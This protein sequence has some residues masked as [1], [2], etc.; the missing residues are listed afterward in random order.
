MRKAWE[1]SGETGKLFP[2]GS[3]KI[4]DHTGLLGGCAGAAPGSPL[5][6]S[7]ASPRLE[8]SGARPPFPVLTV[9][10]EVSFQGDHSS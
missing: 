1:G 2:P 6:G 9:V 10:S 8:L 7:A 3:L 5:P 4:Q